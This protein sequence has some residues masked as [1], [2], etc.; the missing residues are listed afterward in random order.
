MSEEI[1]LG[2]NESEKLLRGQVVDGLRSGGVEDQ[3]VKEK[4]IEWVIK[5]EEKVE[6]AGRTVEARVNFEIEKAKLYFEGGYIDEALK[7]LN[8]ALY[9]AEQENRDDLAE[10]ISDEISRIEE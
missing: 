5:Q 9:V 6:S 3:E 2:S 7:T 10:K 1:E 8:L 4:L